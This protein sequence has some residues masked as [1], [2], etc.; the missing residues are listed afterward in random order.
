MWR[1]IQIFL[2]GW[3]LNRHL[4]RLYAKLCVMPV[5]VRRAP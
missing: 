3:W 4:G 5:E 2:Y 1:P